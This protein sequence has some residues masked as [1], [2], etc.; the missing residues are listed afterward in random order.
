MR[1]CGLVYSNLDVPLCLPHAEPD[2]AAPGGYAPLP[3][4]G[5]GSPAADASRARIAAARATIAA[6]N[7]A[8]AERGSPL[9]AA[10][11]EIQARKHS[12]CAAPKESSL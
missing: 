10:A 12:L 6:N 5:E 11:A 9:R 3:A 2:M 1:G 4:E 8:R 7:A